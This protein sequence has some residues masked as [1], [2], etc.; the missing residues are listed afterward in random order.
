QSPLPS[1]VTSSTRT[2]MRLLHSPRFMSA[3]AG[4]TTRPRPSVG[5]RSSTS[6][7]AM[8]SRQ[9]RH[10]RSSGASSAEPLVPQLGLR[11]LGR[12]E[13]EAHGARDPRR[14][15]ELHLSVLD[16]L[17]LVAPRIVEVE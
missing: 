8:S 10:T 12:L 3:S 4:R 13:L 17:Y 16:D 1:R 11:P 6:R 15:R 5:P 9:R 7:K 14:L 2:A